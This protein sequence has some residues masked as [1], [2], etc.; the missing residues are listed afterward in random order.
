MGETLRGTGRGEGPGGGEKDRG[1][2]SCCFLTLTT[3]SLPMTSLLMEYNDLASLSLEYFF[4]LFPR[5]VF[6]LFFFSFFHIYFTAYIRDFV[7]QIHTTLKKKNHIYVYIRRKTV[8]REACI[9]VCARNTNV[10]K[11]PISETVVRRV[12]VYKHVSDILDVIYTAGQ[13][14]RG[15]SSSQ[16]RANRSLRFSLLFFLGF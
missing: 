7:I 3:M 2:T 4:F 15:S 1:A 14:A 13:T 5:L 6:V 16:S 12:R 11:K 10:Y 9:M 8:R